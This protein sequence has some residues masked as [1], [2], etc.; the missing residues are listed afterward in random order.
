MKSQID[1]RWL[2]LTKRELVKR[3]RGKRGGSLEDGGEGRRERT[4]RRI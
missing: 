3:E 2:P 4:R 1:V